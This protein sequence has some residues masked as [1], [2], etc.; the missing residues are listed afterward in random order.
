MR[1]A[2]SCQSIAIM[3]VRCAVCGMALA[4]AAHAQTGTSPA[5]DDANAPTRALRHLALPPSGEIVQQPGD[6]RAANETVALFPRGHADVVRW[7]EARP[8]DARTAGLPGA[9]ASEAGP[10]PHPH[11]HG[12]RP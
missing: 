7:E 10:T 2:H 5:V 4:A 9:P 1:P 3:A 12:A 6:W 11:R 8:R